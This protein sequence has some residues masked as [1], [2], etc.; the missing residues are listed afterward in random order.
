MNFVNEYERMVK[1]YRAQARNAFDS[2]GVS[3]GFDE[4][5]FMTMNLS[6]E[7]MNMAGNGKYLA[8]NAA[9]L[10]LQ[11]HLMRFPYIPHMVNQLTN[12]KLPD[13]KIPQDI[14]M[15]LA[16]SA[17]FIRRYYYED[18]TTEEEATFISG[19][20]QSRYARPG[21]FRYGRN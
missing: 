17:A 1:L 20:T 9:K 12:Y 11:K 5:V 13:E 6:A 3:K 8:L 21:V 19:S 15:T 18:V 16:M 7:G 10:L 2:T 4:L 14:V